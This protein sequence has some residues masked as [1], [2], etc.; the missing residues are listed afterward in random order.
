MPKKTKPKEK[1]YYYALEI[2][3]GSLYKCYLHRFIHGEDRDIYISRSR[4]KRMW[5]DDI[6]NQE[7][8][9][10]GWKVCDDCRGTHEYVQCG[11]KVIKK[12]KQQESDEED[13]RR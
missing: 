4:A 10:E 11:V 5:V 7:A 6:E 9:T 13:R 8:P 3:Y 1:V 2:P 12:T